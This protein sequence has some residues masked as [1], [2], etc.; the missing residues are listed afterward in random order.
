MIRPFWKY[1]TLKIF[2]RVGAPIKENHKEITENLDV[3]L[4][5]SNHINHIIISPS[6]LWDKLRLSSRLEV[7]V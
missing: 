5:K 3:D 7:R 4:V 2:P 6:R 1:S